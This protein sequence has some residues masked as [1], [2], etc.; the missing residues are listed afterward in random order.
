[1]ADS[2]FNCINFL[3]PAATFWGYVY[4]FSNVYKYIYKFLSNVYKHLIAHNKRNSVAK[5]WGYLSV[6]WIYT[7]HKRKCFKTYLS[8]KKIK[9]WLFK[10][11]FWDFKSKS[12]L[13]FQSDLKHS[14]LPLIPSPQSSW[15]LNR[16]EMKVIQTEYSV[17]GFIL[18][19]SVPDVSKW[20]SYVNREYCQATSLTLH[21][22]LYLD[23]PS[24]WPVWPM[25]RLETKGHILNRRQHRSPRS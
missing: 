19:R 11:K 20:Q 16:L 3:I 13:T 7:L 9:F 21:L 1:M 5:E 23:W 18:W 24:Q 2:A 4:I 22:M 25:A 17:V 8:C 12:N 14:S 10:T 6:G 15:L